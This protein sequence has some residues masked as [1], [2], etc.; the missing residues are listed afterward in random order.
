M[1]KMVDWLKARSQIILGLGLMCMVILEGCSASSTTSPQHT[2]DELDN[3]VSLAI[4]GIGKSY[5]NGECLT[6][7]HT[8]LEA[9]EKSGTV[10]AY[11][12]A[13]VGWF[14]FENGIFTKVSGSGAIPTVMTFSRNNRGEYSLICYKEPT[15][16]MTSYDSKKKL[17]PMRLW[18]KVLNSDRYYPEL[19]RQQENQAGAYLANVG[20]TARISAAYVEKQLVE[21]NVSASNKLFAELPLKDAFLNNCPHW[22]GT[23][24]RI[25]DGVRY[26]FETTQSKSADGYDLISFKKIKT[27][28]SI[29]EERKY[30]IEGSSPRLID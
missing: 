8:V 12:V 10:V 15:D 24:E 13:S 3:A 17:F 19:A 30:K 26:I 9:E 20:R 27:D 11:T 22:R 5:Y 29:L 4:K 2:L 6:E 25:V 21:I 28:G 23:R 18:D 1:S 14:G 16:G 7:G